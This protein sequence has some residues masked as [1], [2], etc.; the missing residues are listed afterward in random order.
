MNLKAKSISFLNPLSPES[1]ISI[2]FFA[3]LK[4]RA[5]AK[6]KTGISKMLQAGICKNNERGKE[7]FKKKKKA[8]K[9]T[10]SD[11]KSIA[12]KM[13]KKTE[14]MGTNTNKNNRFKTTKRNCFQ[15]SFV[16]TSPQATL[17][18]VSTRNILF[19]KNLAPK[20]PPKR[21]NRKIKREKKKKFL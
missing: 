6:I 2:V 9:I 17:T 10:P 4:P 18:I 11:N 8:P 3:T 14:K 5:Q 15:F 13:P 19:G 7:S 16:V 1:T 21:P 12:G 20:K